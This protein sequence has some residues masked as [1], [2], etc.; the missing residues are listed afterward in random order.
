MTIKIHRRG[1]DS[2][3]IDI[4][5]EDKE[6]TESF[7]NDYIIPKLGDKKSGEI[8]L[9][10]FDLYGNNG[11]ARRSEY[12]VQLVGKDTI[13]LY[14]TRSYPQRLA[15]IQL[16]LTQPFV[17]KDPILRAEEIIKKI[18]AHVGRTLHRVS[19]LDLSVHFSGW[20][21]TN[22]NFFNLI[23]SN[24]SPEKRGQDKID[25]IRVGSLKSELPQMF[26]YSKSEDLISHPRKPSPLPYYHI[27]PLYGANIQNLE[28]AWTTKS[29]DRF[30]VRTLREVARA[31][32]DLWHFCT[33]S[34]VVIADESGEI[35]PDWV[36]L[37]KAFTEKNKNLFT[38]RSKKKQDPNLFYR[39]ELAAKDI[40]S[41]MKLEK[42][43]TH[44]E[45]WQNLK[46]YF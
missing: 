28:F 14:L 30:S 13:E 40:R 9:F 7:V 5:A 41:I 46:N 44:D 43:K 38:R 39:Y 12:P 26:T 35:V 36:A 32:P 23:R 45:V 8:E 10:G 19:R 24:H 25:F 34:F 20:V 16:K 21:I 15:P 4:F 11:P 42:S 31:I 22:E 17:W 27:K 1:I 3:T 33:N 18:E 2:L 29:L 6:A 37:S